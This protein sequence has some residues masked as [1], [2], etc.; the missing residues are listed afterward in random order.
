[1]LGGHAVVGGWVRIPLV[2]AQVVLTVCP[3]EICLGVLRNRKIYTRL[4]KS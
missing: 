1:M 4:L 2:S 3:Y